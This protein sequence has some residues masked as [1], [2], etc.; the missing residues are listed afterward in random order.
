M[1]DILAIVT[2]V[3]ADALEEPAQ[4]AF[5]L[6]RELGARLTVMIS[7]IEPFHAAPPSQPDNMQGDDASRQPPSLDDILERT[8]ALVRSEARG[9]GVEHLIL[10][11]E[12]KSAA[13]RERLIALAQVRDLTIFSAY[14]PLV[15]PRLGLVEAALFRSGRPVL[16]MPRAAQTF[17]NGT[18]I[19]GW[20]AT[21]AAVRALHDAMPFLI[22]ARQIVVASVSDDKELPL[23]ASG[24]AICSYL[25]QQKINASFQALTRQQRSVGETLL[26]HA[27]RLGA[28]LLVMGGF[29]HPRERE[30]L[31][32]SA[33]RDVFQSYLDIPVLLSH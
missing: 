7:T 6:A 12:E 27:R 18:V 31:F 15:Y 16:L 26:S 3:W 14:G 29:G 23:A 1:K 11:P 21:R 4:H 2:P 32:G 20:D 25:R 13:L 8:A 30:F 19:V 9:A 22:R 28:N 24:P 5:A 17:A 10:P 33:T